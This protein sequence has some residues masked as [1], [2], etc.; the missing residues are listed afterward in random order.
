M[1]ALLVASAVT[2]AV[3]A[4]SAGNSQAANYDAQRQAHDYNANVALQNAGQARNEAGAAEDLQRRR[5]SRVLAEQRGGVTQMGVDGSAGTAADLYRQALE[6]SELDALNIR[7]EGESR[8]RGFN[9][10]ADQQRYASS[11]AKTNSKAARKAGYL[12]A[13]GSTLSVAGGYYK[14]QA[15]KQ[16]AL[17]GISGG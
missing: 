13:I 17:S 7:Y 6:D 11:L 5:A 16:A 3:G 15:G 1:E 9:I 2:S 10:E 8:A 14:G 12:N 4:I